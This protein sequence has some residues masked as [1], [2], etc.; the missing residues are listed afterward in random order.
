[1]AIQ[2]AKYNSAPPSGERL[3]IIKNNIQ[4]DLPYK[5]SISHENISIRS[6]SEKR[7]FAHGGTL[8]GDGYVDSKKIKI[9]FDIKA[10]TQQEHDTVVNNMLSLFMGREYKL[11]NERMDSY[12]N[13][14]SLESI[15]HKWQKGYKNRWSELDLSLLLTDPFRYAVN[16]T[17][18][19]KELDVSDA[20]EYSYVELLNVGS[21]DT[22]LLINLKPVSQ[23]PNVEI[24]HI[25]TGR[26]CKIK[27]SLL[28]NP[29][30]VVIN[31]RAGTVFRGA[32]NAINA[33]SGQFLAAT[34]GKNTYKIKCGNAGIVKFAIQARWLI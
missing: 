16:E 20:D 14:A 22:P 9:S 28:I 34:C 24:T 29:H 6:K 33:Y 15:K 25:E 17:T 12:Y 8:S 23:M 18:V 27:D 11:V 7:A 2:R 4:T 21:V 5:Y 10:Y 31:S 13:I 26:Q 1:M 19:S 3:I 32:N 30:T